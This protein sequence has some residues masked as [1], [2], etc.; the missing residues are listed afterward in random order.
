MTGHS[1][2]FVAKGKK[3]LELAPVEENREVLLKSA[4]G[5]SGNLRAPTLTVNDK[6]IVGYS[7]A[8]YGHIFG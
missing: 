2:I 6:M 1:M 8:M 5:R 4:M 7:E 3:W